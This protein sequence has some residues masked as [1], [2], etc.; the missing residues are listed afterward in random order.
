MLLPADLWI[1][2]F[3][4]QREHNLPYALYYKLQGSFDDDKIRKFVEARGLKLKIIY[5]KAYGKDSENNYY[6]SDPRQF[7]Q[8]MFNAEMLFT[9]SFH[10]LVFALIF[11]KQFYANRL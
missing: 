8:L 5:H 3:K 9:S 2:E 7:L 11:H 10:G 6:T 4:L 1:E